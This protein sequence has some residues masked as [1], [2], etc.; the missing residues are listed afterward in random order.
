MP[1]HVMHL[2]ALVLDSCLPCHAPRNLRIVAS[3]MHACAAHA[4]LRTA[5]C[6]TP[7]CTW[8][9]MPTMTLCAH[10]CAPALLQSSGLLK[11][12]QSMGAPNLLDLRTECSAPSSQADRRQ[13]WRACGAGACRPVAGQVCAV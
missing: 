10:Q 3:H 5:V 11:Q 1:G 7:L 6:P 9:P 2:A 8:L 12:L 13:A 4:T